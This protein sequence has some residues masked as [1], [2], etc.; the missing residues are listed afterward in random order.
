[1][2]R[3]IISWFRSNEDTKEPLMEWNIYCLLVAHWQ[4]NRLEGICNHPNCHKMGGIALV[5]Q[6]MKGYDT[7]KCIGS[8]RVAKADFAWTA[9]R[10][11]H[12][13]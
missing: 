8:L 6:L 10:R 11:I 13:V 7:N 1:M 9:K 3:G 2:K 5:L 12:I 4:R